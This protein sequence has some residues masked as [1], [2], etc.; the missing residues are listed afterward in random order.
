MLEFTL[1]PQRGEMVESLC[2]LIRI[3]SVKG[4]PETLMPYGKG[5]FNALM[6]ML[7]MADHLDF[8][9]VNLYS[10][11]GYV[12]YGEGDE[13]LAVLTHLDVVP[14]GDGWTFPPF[15]G[16]VQDGRVY[17]RGAIDNKGPA[18]AALYALHAIK[19]N[20]VELDKKVRLLFGCD[21][22]SGWADIDFYKQTVGEIPDMAISPDA[23]FPVVN[24]EKGAAH[25]RL[26]MPREKSEDGS[27]SRLLKLLSIEGGDRVN[28]VPATAEC[29][30][31]CPIE[32]VTK[33]A[34]LFV[35]ECPAQLTWEQAGESQ[36][37]FSCRGRSAHGSKPQDGVNAVAWLIRFLS[38]LPLA[39]DSMGRTVRTIA[40]KIGTKTDGSPMGISRDDE[41]GPLTLNLG[42]IHTLEDAVEFGLDIRYP[43]SEPES[44]I[45]EH[46]KAAFDKFDLEKTS[47]LPPHF[48]APD[49]DLVTGL[50]T[51]YEDVT[52]EKGFC[53]SM[54]GATYARAFPNSVA[55]GPLFPGQPATE[56]QPDEY[57]EVDS[58]VRVADLLAAAIV[59]LCGR[60]SR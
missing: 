26:S 21:E 12:D 16:T 60:K 8:D 2:K 29:L 7:G 58:L 27:S 48:V 40:K 50:L 34:N 30:L 55:F 6:K 54:G 24:S 59:R 41:S 36:L 13:T 56:H 18:V 17:G 9:S 37:R 33:L 52:H 43:V 45:T 53:I 19:E 31:D 23:E 22:E 15:E 25:Y 35:Q 46:V 11:M 20:G 38:T 39:D 5:V 10:H 3:E 44:F 32:P 49:S 51:A 47:S 14:A 42:F 4:K 28:V 57:I 1:A